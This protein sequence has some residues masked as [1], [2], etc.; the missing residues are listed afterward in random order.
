MIV[1]RPILPAPIVFNKYSNVLL[2]PYTTQRSSC[3]RSYKWRGFER[4]NNKKLFARSH[5]YFPMTHD[6]SF[7]CILF[8]SGKR[9]YHQQIAIELSFFYRSG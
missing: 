3:H 7:T 5:A 9:T 6:I 4:E 2:I 8:L 1:H